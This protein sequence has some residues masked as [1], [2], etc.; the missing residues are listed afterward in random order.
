M[1]LHILARHYAPGR[2]KVGGPEQTAGREFALHSRPTLQISLFEG[3]IRWHCLCRM[4]LERDCVLSGSKPKTSRCLKQRP[5]ILGRVLAGPTGRCGTLE[6]RTKTTTG[7]SLLRRTI[8]ANGFHRTISPRKITRSTVSTLMTSLGRLHVRRSTGQFC[9]ISLERDCVLSGSKPQT[10]RSL[11][12]RPS[13]LGRVLA[14][15]TGR[16]GTLKTRTKTTT[17]SLL[18]TMALAN[19]FHRTISPRKI[20]VTRST[21]STLMTSLAR[22]DLHVRRSTG[23]VLQSL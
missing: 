1:G 10:R 3:V 5:S 9:L 14:C 6:T 8:R 13:I 12:Q 2:A 7:Q 16:C 20:E 17:R 11:K 15:P 22:I 19:G 18:L 21:V 23:Q 4:S